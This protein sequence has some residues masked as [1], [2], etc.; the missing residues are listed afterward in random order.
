M[1]W[2]FRS[3]QLF[4]NNGSISHFSKQIT[5]IDHFFFLNMKL[6]KLNELFFTL[7]WIYPVDEGTERWTK[8]RNISFAIT[9]MTFQICAQIA[10]LV[11][12]IEN[13]TSDL[14]NLLAGVFQFSAV[15][16][17]VYTVFIAL[18]IRS[19]IKEIFI[20]FRKFYDS[21]KLRES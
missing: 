17:G 1:P 11:Y 18:S 9:A 20:E 10:S 5:Q 8:I 7:L 14:S 16:A 21:S 19:E 3:N 12:M 2:P 15:T 6:L 4:V 13:T